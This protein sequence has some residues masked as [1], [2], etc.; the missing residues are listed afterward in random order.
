MNWVNEYIQPGTYQHYK[1]GLYVLVDVVTH[2]DNTEGKMDKLVDPLVIYRDLTGT[3]EHVNG[4]PVVPHKR[5]ARTLSSFT[6][7]VEHNKNIVP[8]F[9]HV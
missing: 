3:V 2:A 6:S 7:N 5:Y 9:K 4:K 8:R 1:G